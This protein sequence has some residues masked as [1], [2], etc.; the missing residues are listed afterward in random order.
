[1]LCYCYSY[2]LV[3]SYLSNLCI[4]CVGYWCYS[5]GL[6]FIVLG[7]FV[8]YVGVFWAILILDFAVLVG[9]FSDFGRADTGKP[10]QNYGVFRKSEAFLEF[11]GLI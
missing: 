3:V 9:A 10:V 1:M 11:L 7:R 4:D 6:L 2:L 8:G 5:I